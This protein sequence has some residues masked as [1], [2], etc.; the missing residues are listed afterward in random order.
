MEFQERLQ[1]IMDEKKLKQVNLAELTG[2]SSA[3]INHLVSGRT[4]DPKFETVVKVADALDVSLDYLAG[5]RDDAAPRLTR[6]ESVLLSDY[7]G[8]TP[9]RRRKAA[10]AVRDQRVLSQ[11][12]ESAGMSFESAEVDLYRRA[13]A[14]ERVS[15]AEVRPAIEK[16][17]RRVA[18]MDERERAEYEAW[19]AG[20][21]VRLAGGEKDEG[22][23]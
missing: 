7:R 23:A 20:E 3:Q 15:D 12:Q 10:D 13:A 4:K 2:L 11:A 9:E 6:D 14:G 5:T 18:V 8:C 16:D 1:K 21:I 22:A 19:K 17:V